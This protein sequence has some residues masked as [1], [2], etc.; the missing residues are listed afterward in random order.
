MTCWLIWATTPIIGLCQLYT[1]QIL[2][3]FMLLMGNLS[4][5]SASNQ[6]TIR[7]L[8]RLDTR[9]TVYAESLNGCS[10]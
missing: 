7:P 1:G 5:G 9:E 3:S 8:V 10:I 4:S 2:Y 6:G